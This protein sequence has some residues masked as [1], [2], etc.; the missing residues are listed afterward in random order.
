MRSFAVGVLFVLLF[1]SQ[2]MAQAVSAPRSSSWQSTARI[3]GLIEPHDPFLRYTTS[4]E[5]EDLVMMRQNNER[6]WQALRD[7]LNDALREGI[8]QA[9]SV[10]PSERAGM[11]RIFIKDQPLTYPELIATLDQN[12]QRVSGLRTGE[13]VFIT[14][15]GD[16]IN[17][18]NFVDDNDSY[19]AN[20][21]AI[22]L[23]EF[24]FEVLI[25]ENGMKVKPTQLI[26]GTALYP[27]RV[28]FDNNP[29]DFFNDLENGLAFLI[30][31]TEDTTRDFFFTRG[32]GRNFSDG[33]TSF[34]DLM[35]S[36]S[37]P[38]FFFSIDGIELA[39]AMDRPFEYELDFI[40][41]EARTQLFSIMMEFTYGEVP[42][43][44]RQNRP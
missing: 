19:Y 40:R 7:S 20:L 39:R 29:N 28:T 12:L 41:E 5:N 44:L 33:M 1:C 13:V 34:Y 26:L 21:S 31:L 24:E 36:F 17:L 15:M 3:T 43:I 14:S 37:Y 35:M 16:V 2:V 22:S 6:F 4:R 30:D 18:R 23:Y 9:Y 8:V 27:G 32:I 10:R 38:H 11:E 25:D 42:D